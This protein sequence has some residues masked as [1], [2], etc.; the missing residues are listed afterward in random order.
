MMSAAIITRNVSRRIIDS[1]VPRLKNSLNMVLF[2]I[3]NKSVKNSD[4]ENT[5]NTQ[6]AFENK[7]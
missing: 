3:Y 2:L 1:G 7:R 6:R 5:E 4:T